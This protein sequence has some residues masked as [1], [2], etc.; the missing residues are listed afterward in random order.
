[1][2][3]PQAAEQA[4]NEPASQANGV[5]SS[6]STSAP[7]TGSVA[8]TVPLGNTPDTDRR[9]FILPGAYRAGTCQLN[10]VKVVAPVFVSVAKVVPCR[11]VTVTTEAGGKPDT[12]QVNVQ[13]LPM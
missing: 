5:D 9:A 12:A 6:T 1:M 4:S 10:V 13:G 2:P 3:D 7:A 11:A 8:G